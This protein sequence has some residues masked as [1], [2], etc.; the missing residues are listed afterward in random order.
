VHALVPT[1]H[2]EG[3]HNGVWGEQRLVSEEWIAAARTPTA[4][5]P[6]YGY[7]NWFLNGAVPGRD[8]TLRRA[9]P[10]APATSVLFIGAGS[11]VVYVD[12]ENDLVAVLRWLDGESMDGF[13]ALLLAALE[14]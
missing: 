1:E 8:G 14:P 4:P 7:M 12:W 2:F 10:S 6:S 11:N 5:N 13:L 3:E 9:W